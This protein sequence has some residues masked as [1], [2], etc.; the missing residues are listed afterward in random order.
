M[1]QEA[2]QSARSTHRLV[3][4]VATVI[5][6]FALS[7][8]PVEDLYTL[9]RSQVA[10]ATSIKWSNYE[11]WVNGQL[12]P[13]EDE[14]QKVLID[15]QT[16]RSF[17]D[18]QPIEDAWELLKPFY[19]AY[20][21][22]GP[23]TNR[24]TLETISGEINFAIDTEALWNAIPSDFGKPSE[25]TPLDILRFIK[26]NE[27]NED[28]EFYG[29]SLENAEHEV[30][31]LIA[32]NALELNR[33]NPPRVLA[34]SVGYEA[35]A[36]LRGSNRREASSSE[37]VENPICIL[38]YRLNFDWVKDIP[39][40]RDQVITDEIEFE[41]FSKKVVG[42]SIA[43]WL[44]NEYPDLGQENAD[45]E[46]VPFVGLDHV[47]RE[48]ADRPLS[49]AD[50]YLSALAAEER[51]RGD[52]V[53]VLGVTIPAP[54]LPIVGPLAILVILFQLYRLLSHIGQHSK[55]KNKNKILS[56]FV[57]PVLHEKRFWWIDPLVTLVILPLLAQIII[58]YKLQSAEPFLLSIG[59]IVTIIS[60]IMAILIW[61]QIGY[62]RRQLHE[63]DIENYSIKK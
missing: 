18:E 45:G 54:F 13:V 57:W 61:K 6:L 10:A 20:S 9:A 8:I 38:R 11:N 2:L 7:V 42:T 55:Q 30:W 56:E 21:V 53:T 24:D 44:K 26:S 36:V 28:A 41:P 5:G 52:S 14:R 16:Y 60:I 12:E 50:L 17:G 1:F 31:R 29:V 35:S 34:T 51:Q 25:V 32:S 4:T 48:I 27:A 22:Y 19:E 58:T 49:D 33:G 43:D 62:L 15:K 59:W 3:F 40:P 63:A 47:W 23:L 39:F 46:F 37:E